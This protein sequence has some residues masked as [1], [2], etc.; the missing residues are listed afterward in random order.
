MTDDTTHVDDGPDDATR[1]LRRA[2]VQRSRAHAG[3]SGF[4]VGAV[5]VSA[6]GN[7]YDGVNV[8]N[9]S[10]G[11]TMC[12]ERVAIGSMVA[13]G[14]RSGIALVAVAG[15]GDATLTPCGA[16]RQVIA[17]FARPETPIVA[18]AHD[19]GIARWRLDELLPAA[20]DEHRLDDG[21]RTPSPPAD[22]GGDGEAS[23]AQ[24]DRGHAGPAPTGERS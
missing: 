15:P 20:F 7:T 14:D 22:A 17:E 5:V 21:R 19:G 3:Y 2:D 13:A 12:A 16:C 6:D 11:L 23:P 18:R 24:A 1:W 8:E 10:Y 9:A 4:A